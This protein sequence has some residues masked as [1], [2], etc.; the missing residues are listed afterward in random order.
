M[1]SSTRARR[2]SSRTKRTYRPSS[3]ATTNATRLWIAI[4]IGLLV[5]LTIAVGAQWLRPKA[6]PTQADAAMEGLAEGR[7]L[8]GA[9]S[10][11]A[12]QPAPDFEIVYADGRRMRL[13]ELRG[14]PVLI[15]FWA[16]WCPPCRREMPD[17]IRA[18]QAHQDEGLIILAVN[19]EEP[20]SRAQAFAEEFGIPF[21]IVL[22]P[23]GR[24]SDQYQV[25]NLPSS[26]F[27]GRDGIISARWVGMLT[28]EVLNKYLERIL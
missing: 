4:A 14:Q 28:P 18:Y 24:V 6:E 16:T 20:A 25:R 1:G 15:N 12:G 5:V 10:P 26:I 3:N 17:L 2:S 19:I 21:P 9:G 23:E 13:S 8:S 7:P 22:D 11:V 27:I